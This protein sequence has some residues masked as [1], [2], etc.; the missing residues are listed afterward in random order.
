[1]IIIDNHIHY[2]EFDELKFIIKLKLKYYIN[3]H[4]NLVRSIIKNTN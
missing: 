3:N 1:M 4:N 2:N